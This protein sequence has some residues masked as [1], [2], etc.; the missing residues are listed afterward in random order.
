MKKEYINEIWRPIKGYEGLYEVSNLGR[1][2]SLKRIV[3][4]WD[5][6]RTI[7]ERIL[8]T[9]K[10]G[11]NGYLYVNLS[12]EG[13]HK[14][15]IVHR[16]V[17]EAFISNSDNL[18]QVNHI[19]EVKTDNRVEN[20]EWCDRKYNCNYGKR[21]KI[22]SEKNTNGKCSK[23]V[24]QYTLDGEFVKE[25]QSTKECKRN[26]F[27][28]GAVAACCRGERKTHKGFIWKYKEDK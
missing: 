25:W 9:I 20:L 4:K 26:G 8:N 3:K 16:L 10:K 18:P 19:N 22:I 7:P 13:K 6:Y 11:K 14:T 2:K 5:G 27:N 1:V 17:A 23:I 15:F 12:K 28:Y 21:N 24:L